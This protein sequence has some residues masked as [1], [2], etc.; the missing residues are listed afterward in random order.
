MNCEEAIAYIHSL[1]KFG[2]RPG[3]ERISELCK[4]LG[5]P[6]IGMKFIHVAGTNGKGSTSTFIS[7]IL[8]Y[9]GCN[10]GLYTSPY[11]IDFRERIQYNGSMIEPDELAECVTE[12]KR[13]QQKADF[14]A[15]EFEAVTAAAFLYFKRK[16]CDYVVLEVGLGGRFDATNVIPSPVAAVIASISMDHMAVLGNTIEKIAFEK[17]GIIKEGST[18]ISYP[19]QRPEALAVI[20]KT[21][22]DKQVPLI[23]PDITK[24]RIG[25]SDLHGTNAEYKNIKFILLLAGEHMVYNTV[26]AIEA[27]KAVLPDISEEALIQGI[28]ASRMPARLELISEK[29]TVILDGGHNEDCAEALREFIIKNSGGKRIIAVTSMMADKDYNKYLSLVLPLVSETVTCRANVPRALESD[30]LAAAAFA[31]CPMVT[32]IPNPEAAVKAALERAENDDIVIICGSFYLA[33]EVRAYLK[34]VF[35]ND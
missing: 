14:I 21:C 33:G 9:A 25:K 19:L 2:I 8:K 22:T 17:C 24:L 7:N 16:K 32:D 28:A 30:E 13:I 27:V 15:T 5:N 31:Y 20:K 11:V 23:F 18:V 12:V 26:T 35:P 3:L 29:P 1:E 4:L 6:Q 34:E 10:V